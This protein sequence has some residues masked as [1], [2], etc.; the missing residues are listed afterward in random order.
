MTIY[1]FIKTLSLEQ[2]SDFLTGITNCDKCPAESICEGACD[3]QMDKWLK[4]EY[5]DGE[6]NG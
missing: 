1:E 5:K 4:Q 6:A 3:T 2:L